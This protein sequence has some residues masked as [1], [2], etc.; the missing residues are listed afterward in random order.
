MRESEVSH[1][2]GRWEERN[3]EVTSNTGQEAGKKRII[4]T[5]DRNVSDHQRTGKTRRNLKEL[6][7]SRVT[8]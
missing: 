4:L 2:Q 5:K 3:F 1:H 8:G 6:L 7:I